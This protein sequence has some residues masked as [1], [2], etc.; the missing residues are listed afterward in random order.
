MVVAV[1]ADQ[2]GGGKLY[3]SQ[4]G[5]KKRKK[6]RPFRAKMMLRAKKL[7]RSRLVEAPPVLFWT[8]SGRR[9]L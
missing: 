8:K 9:R 7:V 3:H 1:I 4:E 2:A 6:A 5:H